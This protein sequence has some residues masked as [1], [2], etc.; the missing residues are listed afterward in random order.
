[1][2]QACKIGTGATDEHCTHISEHVVGKN[3]IF[4]SSNL[5]GGIVE[6]SCCAH[7]I[8]SCPSMGAF[9]HSAGTAPIIMLF[10]PGTP[11][12][13]THLQKHARS[14]QNSIGY[15]EFRTLGPVAASH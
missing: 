6:A 12:K 4:I 9:S 2:Q 10:I 8:P 5:C 3:T 13:T 15:A 11:L 14:I 7:P 1:M